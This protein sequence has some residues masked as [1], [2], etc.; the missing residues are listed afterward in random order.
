MRVRYGAKQPVLRKK[1][2]RYEVYDLRLGDFTLSVTYLNAH[3][4]T[5]GNS[6][7]WEEAYYIIE[8][9]GQILINDMPIVISA[10]DFIIIPKGARH[11]V[12]SLDEPIA[13][14]C[15]FK[16]KKNGNKV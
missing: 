12:F 2:E 14:L 11:R 10:G 1:D 13:F 5:T 9:E 15:V 4:S 8:G 16:E 7:D 6:H 3:K